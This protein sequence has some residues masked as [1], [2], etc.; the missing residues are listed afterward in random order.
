MRRLF[1]R[2][3]RGLLMTFRR[4][5]LH[6]AQHRH[7]KKLKMRR[8]NGLRGQLPTTERINSTTFYLF[9]FLLLLVKWKRKVF[10]CF[11]FFYKIIVDWEGHTCKWTCWPQILCLSIRIIKKLDWIQFYFVLFFLYQN[12]FWPFL[13]GDSGVSCLYQR[14][15]L[16]MPYL[17]MKFRHQLHEFVFKKINYSS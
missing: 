4:R 15:H 11:F 5:Q 7:K 16:L 12:S 14:S 8:E 9:F 10:F 13:G 1:T 17:K 2:C 3:V 6:T